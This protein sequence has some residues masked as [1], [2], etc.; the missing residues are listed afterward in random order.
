MIPHI[1]P[2]EFPTREI[3]TIAPVL[4]PGSLKWRIITL[5]VSNN[6]VKT[7][8]IPSQ[9]ID[10][11]LGASLD[12]TIKEAEK[13]A[14]KA[15]RIYVER[16]TL[17]TIGP[18]V[19]IYKNEKNQYMPIEIEINDAS[20]ELK[21]EITPLTSPYDD[22]SIATGQTMHQARVKA[23]PLEWSWLRPLHKISS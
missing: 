14:E 5:S 17:S 7:R 10:P 16:A 18:F 15:N 2:K 12:V 6:Q 8:H 4:Q 20:D 11:I 22:F 3:Y 13:L 9:K 19:S 1:E 23:L 21:V